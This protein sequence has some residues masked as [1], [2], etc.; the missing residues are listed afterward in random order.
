MSI[1]SMNLCNFPCLVLLVIWGWQPPHGS[2]PS[3]GVIGDL[4][5]RFQ[6]SNINS[7]SVEIQWTFNKKT[8]STLVGGFSPSWKIV[9]NWDDDIPNIWKI[10]KKK[11][12]VPN[13]YPEHHSALNSDSLEFQCFFFPNKNKKNKF[14]IIQLAYFYHNYLYRNP[15]PH[16]PTI[17]I[18]TCRFAVARPPA[19]CRKPSPGN[20]SPSSQQTCLRLLAVSV[21]RFVYWISIYLFIF[22]LMFCLFFLLSIYDSIYLS[23]Y[24]STYLSIYLSIDRSIYLSIYLSK[25]L[26]INLCACIIISSVCDSACHICYCVHHFLH[27]VV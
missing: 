21:C 3:G 20:P 12:N 26:S 13:H 27:L 23:I 18:G 24:L 17:R 22:I 7:D 14:N 5:G 16:W 4:R 15:G 6:N 8:I 10:I 9:V 19:Q 25:F 2:R 1:K 11:N